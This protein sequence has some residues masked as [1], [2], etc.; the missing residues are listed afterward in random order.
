MFHSIHGSVQFYLCDFHC[1]VSILSLTQLDL[2]KFTSCDFLFF[3]VLHCPFRLLHP[4][5]VSVHFY[6]SIFTTQFPLLSLTQH[7][8]EK[9]HPSYLSFFRSN[10]LTLPLVRINSIHSTQ[11]TLLFHLLGCPCAR[12]CL[13]GCPNY[14]QLRFHPLAVRLAVNLSSQLSYPVH[15]LSTSYLVLLFLRVLCPFL[16]CVANVVLFRCVFRLC[17]FLGVFVCLCLAPL[18]PPAPAPAPAPALPAPWYGIF[19]VLR[20]VA[21]GCFACNWLLCM[22]MLLH[23]VCRVPCRSLRARLL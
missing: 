23:C 22:H 14:F 18:R 8:F 6:F 21:V 20:L 7:G 17:G 2:E 5:H 3:V 16:A 19:F 13:R 11:G 4:I 15:R 1:Y 9:F 12:R 10:F